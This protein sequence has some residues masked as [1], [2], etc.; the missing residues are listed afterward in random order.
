MGRA[1]VAGALAA[2]AAAATAHA[3]TYVQHACRLPDGRPAAADG[4]TPRTDGG[5]AAVAADE[6]R[7]GGGLT[8]ALGRGAGP[9]SAEWVYVA[10]PDTAIAAV[11]LRRR[12]TLGEGSG[13]Q[14]AL[15]G[16]ADRCGAAT[17]C[18]DDRFDLAVPP[19]RLDF[20]LECPAAGCAGDRDPVAV[21]RSARI[22]L[23]DDSP[24]SVLATGGALLA[25]GRVAGRARVRFTATDAGGGVA[26]AMLVVDGRVRARHH[27]GGCRAPYARAVP[28]PLRVTGTLT[29]DSRALAD[30]PHTVAVMVADATGVNRA[31]TATVGIDV[32]NVPRPAVPVRPAPRR[33]TLSASRARLRNGQVLWL[34]ARNGR[35]GAAAAFQVRVGRRWR[36]FAVRRLDA[37]GSARVRHRFRLTFR[38]LRYAFRVVVAGMRRSAPVRVLVE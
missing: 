31:V 11:S 18:G 8:L 13:A 24:P 29:L 2:F 9:A 14:Y 37:T 27:V 16:S 19:G 25:G 35:P 34:R 32:A 23:R 28:C 30:G 7:R 33:V 10:P 12:V 1:W 4:F 17:A 3:G 5:D 22:T 36:T 21:V 15:A 26:L 38:R 20:R 6:C